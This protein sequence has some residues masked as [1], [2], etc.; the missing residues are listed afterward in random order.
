MMSVEQSVEWELVEKLKYWEK[1]CPSA[2]LF[3]TNPTWSDLGSN[4]GRRGGKPVANRLSCGTANSS[5]KESKRINGSTA[6]V[7]KVGAD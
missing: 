6:L 2:T 4:P 7:G 3:T 1:T 5:Y